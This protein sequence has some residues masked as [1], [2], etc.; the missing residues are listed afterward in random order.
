MT[1]LSKQDFLSILQKFLPEGAAWSRALDSML[2]KLLT[3]FAFLFS[4]LDLRLQDLLAELNPATSTELLPDWE[5]FVG[6]CDTCCTSLGTLAERRIRV[7]TKLNEQGG[8][9]RAYFLQLAADLGYLDTTIT[10]FRPTNCEM[11]CEAPIR[12]ERWRFA[13]QVNV[14]QG[15]TQPRPTNCEMHCEA[16]IRDERWLYAW[17]HASFRADSR[18]DSRI[19][20]YA[21]G[22]LECQFMRLKPAHTYV[23]FT[24]EEFA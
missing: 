8:L 18:C 22:A 2:A 14:S 10:E 6:A 7:L 15:G 11:H 4:L 13:W 1:P 19:D 16:P 5:I 23:I 20:S 12:N 17:N 9:S 3:S 21:L 24:Y